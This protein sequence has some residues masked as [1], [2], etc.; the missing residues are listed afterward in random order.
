MENNQSDPTDYQEKTADAHSGDFAFHYWSKDAMNFTIEQKVTGLEPGTY[1]ASV[2]SQGG[3]FDDTASLEFYV[4]ADE[5]MVYSENFMNDG[6]ANWKNPVI[7][8]IEI[9]K[10]T[11][12]IGV[13]VKGNPGS[14]G[15]LDDFTL[16]KT[17]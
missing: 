7:R 9:T 8:D 1:Q 10:D 14:W 4:I 6:W 3:D 13:R 5:D 16:S 17:D 2:F 12:T 11:L 15:T